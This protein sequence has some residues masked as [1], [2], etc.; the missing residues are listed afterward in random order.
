[1]KSVAVLAALVASASAFAPA[2]RTFVR[3]ALQAE[4]E[5]T[6]A[7][8]AKW[9]ETDWEG[10]LDKLQKEAEDRLDDKIQDLM[11]N[12]ESTGKSS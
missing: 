12:V 7:D 11:R 6:P 5:W 3:T 2:S 9:T 8:G 10:K 1:M 4:A